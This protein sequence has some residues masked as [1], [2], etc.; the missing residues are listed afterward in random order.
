MIQPRTSLPE[1]SA[2]AFTMKAGKGTFLNFAAAWQARKRLAA[3]LDGRRPDLRPAGR[4]YG[5]P[6]EGDSRSRPAASMRKNRIAGHQQ[7]RHRSQPPW[8]FDV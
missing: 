8:G 5:R 2:I 4:R 6:T 1:I 3:R 7:A